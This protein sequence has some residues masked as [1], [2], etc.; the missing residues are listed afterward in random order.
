[1]PER[2][3]T[4]VADGNLREEVER[5]S[6][7]NQRLLENEQRLRLAIEMGRI[8]LWIW[9]STDTANPGDWSDR[10]KEIFGLPL[11]AEVTHDM[12]LSAVFPDD[13]ELINRCVMD[14]LSGKDGGSYQTEYRMIRKGDAE[15]GWVHARGQAFFN[16]DGVAIRF[17]GTVMDITERKRAEE[18]LA[19]LN[20]ELER[21]V[22]RRTEALVDANRKLHEEIRERQ[23]IE[24]ELK[25]N[26]DY[27]RLA[28]D[29]IP[30]LV[31]SAM[32][33]G[34]TDYLNK[35]WLDYTG[36]TLQEATNWGWHTAIHQ[37]DLPGLVE[38]WRGLLI[39]GSEGQHEA[40]LRRY[41]GEFRWF[42]FRGVPLY[43]A[44]GKIVRW[45]GTNTDIDDLRASERFA[46]GQV[47]ALSETL[48]AMSRESDPERLL[49]HVVCTMLRQLGGVSLGIWELDE[50]TGLVELLANSEDGALRFAD[51]TDL[52]RSA[53]L[54]PAL[55]SHP[56]WTRFFEKGDICVFG[57][58]TKDPQLVRLSEGPDTK[59]YDWRGTP[60]ANESVRELQDDLTKTGIVATLCVPT[61]VEGKVT[62]LFSI[63]FTSR[64]SFRPE[65]LRLA[66]AL[67]NQAT[68][69]IRLMRLSQRS[70]QAAVEE[71]RNRMAREIHDT[72]AQGF[73]GVIVQLEAA[74]DARHGGLDEAA[75]GHVARA[76]ELARKSL[77]EAR[78]SVQA[79][80]PRALQDQTLCAALEGMICEMTDGLAIRAEFLVKGEPRPVPADHEDH[81]L[82]IGQEVL[83]NVIRHSGAARFTAEL[84]FCEKGVAFLIKDDGRGFDPKAVKG[85]FGF[86]SIRERAELIGG[87][88]QLD[89]GPAGTT[90]SIHVPIA[91]V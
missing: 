69:A 79:L 27:L 39:D 30:G 53:Q 88:F 84:E 59:W 44:H 14:A 91:A 13:R 41:D 78:R 46:L 66:R 23:A 40:R 75:D 3:P 1:M 65:E 38:Y 60:V 11:D 52:R 42:L 54:L 63:R 64:R 2:T 68:L 16:H 12:F 73:T 10:L 89:S 15:P 72:L 8:G 4:D 45:Y 9:D 22:G 82:R 24:E 50:E 70:R 71:E 90:V 47:E 74:E 25:A 37:D 87:R 20:H 83:T 81:L 34:N 5:L 67:S 77:Q 31:W 86:R 36:M 56:V 6:A 7:E 18:S 29:T 19:A 49:Q 26:K 28:I 21:K 51:D 85:G 62:G 33:D 17:I 43:N 58:L 48:D 57:D 61:V 55:E 80:R 32:P 76:A 35:R